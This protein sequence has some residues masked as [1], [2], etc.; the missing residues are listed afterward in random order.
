MCLLIF[1]NVYSLYYPKNGFCAFEYDSA[2][3]DN[4]KVPQHIHQMFFYATDKVVPEMLETN[5]Q[6]WINHNSDFNYTLWNASTTLNLIKS[7]Y[8]QLLSLYESQGHWVRRADVGRYVILYEH[9]GIYAD[10]DIAPRQNIAGLLASFT[11]KSGV[12]LYHTK[13][14]GVSNDFMIA[15][16]HHP[17][18]KHVICGLE[19]GNQWYI[20]PY[21]TTI[22]T[23]GPGYL[24][25]RYITYA[26]RTEVSVVEE[27]VLR[28]YLQHTE[29]GAWHDLDSK[30]IWWIYI[31]RNSVLYFIFL[32]AC[33]ATLVI[34]VLKLKGVRL[35]AFIMLKS[36]SKTISVKNVICL[37]CIRLLPTDIVL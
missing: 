25:S 28:P 5:R 31:N 18:L 29:G 35:K 1:K 22:M 37:L 20:L 10:L 30:V 3:R 7:K 13:P 8:P 15:K 26:N 32:L 4:S 17:F 36:R 34:I 9:G 6:G 11:N 24:Y 2:P 33:L 23:T 21:L 27:P 19:A 16:S 12:V 14:I